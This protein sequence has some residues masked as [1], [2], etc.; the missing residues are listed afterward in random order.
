M[1]TLIYYQLPLKARR[2]WLLAA[3][4]YFYMSWSPVY[5]LLIAFSTISTYLFALLIDNSG[6]SDNKKRGSR[7]KLFVIL[8]FIIN[9]S[10]LFFFKYFNFA[11]SSVVGLLSVIGIKTSG[12]SFSILLPVGISFYTFQALGYAADV[13]RGDIK[14]ERN[15]IKY[16]LFVSFFPQLVAGPIERSKNLLRQFDI[17]QVF[18]YSSVKNG[19]LLM[20]WGFFQ[21]MVIA[22]NISKT[23]NL[24]YG[25][26]QLFSGSQ[27]TLATLLFAVQIYCDFAGYS[28]IARGAAEVMGFKL[29][30]NFKQPYFAV[31]IR[32][33]WR[34]WHISLSS[35]F[36]DYVYIPLGGGR[37]SR[38]RRS[39]NTMITFLISGLWHGADWSFVVWG[40]FHGSLQLISDAVGK[41]KKSSL[42]HSE[43][44][45]TGLMRFARTAGTFLLVD[46]AWIFF[47]AA[48]LKDAFNII[49]RIFS[50]FRIRSLFDGSL[51]VM[52]I[53]P[54]GLLISCAAIAVLFCVD[55]LQSKTDIRAGI[56]KR[57]AAFRW[58]VYYLLMLS[59]LIFGEYGANQFI[60]FQF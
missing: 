24:I 25:S 59:L 23:V 42:R 55:A 49:F 26:P 18:D 32:D 39:V 45:N 50:D 14:A 1:V 53:L 35:W 2:V 43:S 17:N 37:R 46:F 51:G 12:L 10:I 5:A 52:G 27:L 30:K 60:Y 57:S 21:K 56:S 15:I 13:Y 41:M 28:N 48:N 7:R 8:C 31:S 19:L 3:S 16:A 33:F 22:D 40:G 34:R 38:F 44:G 54:S 58:T 47:R 9:L 6:A 29:T 11:V 36:R 20:A 4:Y